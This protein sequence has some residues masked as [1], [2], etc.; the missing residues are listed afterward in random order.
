MSSF[1]KLIDNSSFFVKG[2]L[3]GK[4]IFPTVRRIID[5]LLS[6]NVA[7]FIYESSYS[8]YNW[9]DITDYK[10]ILSF[11]VKGEFIIPVT[12]FIVI[13]FA[14][15][16]IIQTPLFLINHL[17]TEKLNNQLKNRESNINI[18]TQYKIL[19]THKGLNKSLNKMDKI[20]TDSEKMLL[21]IIKAIIIS[22]FFFLYPS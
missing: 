19:F 12:L 9:I 6:I 15:I 13:H 21:F 5:P 17:I 8:K 18:Y 2:Y 22:I 14:I 11:I 7:S 1:D 3:E 10:S 20:K 4:N 16:F